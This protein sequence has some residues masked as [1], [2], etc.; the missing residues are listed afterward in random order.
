MPIRMV[1]DDPQGKKQ[2]RRAARPSGSNGST[3]GGLGGGLGALV[4]NLLPLL[5]RRPKLLIVLVIIGI[6]LYFFMGRGCSGLGVGDGVS[7]FFRG[8]ELNKEVYEETEIFEPLADNKKNPLP[9]RVSLQRYCPT[10]KNQGQQGSC[11]AWA[12]A[13][14]ARTILEAQ[15][16]GQDPD[17]LSFSPAFMYNQISIDHNTCQGSYIKYAMDNMLQV[18]AVP[19]HDFKYD[20]GDCNR[21]PGTTLKRTAGIYKI[22]GFQR[23]TDDSRSNSK[24][25]ESLAIKQ[26]LAK[27]SPVIIGMMVGGSFMQNMLGKEFWNPVSQD[28]LKQGFGGHA[29]CVVGYDDYYE[30]GAFLVMNSWGTE[31]GKDGFAWIRYSDFREFNVESYGLYP[32]G[33]ADK[34]AVSTFEG[35]FGLELN[36]EK[37]TI[38]LR[39]V[40]DHYFETTRQLGQQD[41]F[42]VEL[43]NNVEC[44]TYIFGEE[45]DGSCYTLFPYTAKHSPYCGITGTR[46]FPRDYSMVPDDK[47][48]KDKIAVVITRQPID[49]DDLMNQINRT[50]GRTYEEKLATLLKT[51]SG[52]KLRFS[53]SETVHFE[54]DVDP[55]EVVYFVIGIT[56]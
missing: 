46:L 1:E 53:G 18:G 41:K 4:G 33:N 30:G 31:W 21:Q 43:T 11:V 9:E 3:G 7:N 5:I 20:D 52:S 27:G 42:K 49:Y 47:G 36:N 54:T 44:Y 15:R 51:K 39:Q 48:R 14:A 45:T 16:T 34:N 13:Y 8:G 19:F 24:A 23:L 50:S 32:M 10:P 40:S 38:A 17:K 6:A 28:Y 56:K 22:K 29:M 26:N 12:S 25:Y 37:K 55:G 35:S 2:H